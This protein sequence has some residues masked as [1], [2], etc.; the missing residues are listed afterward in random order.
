LVTREQPGG[1]TAGR[2]DTR[3][4][5]D[6][7]FHC[8]PGNCQL[9]VLCRKIAD[10]TGESMFRAAAHSFLAEVLPAQCFNR[11]KNRFGA[12]PG[13]SPFWGGYLPFCYPHWAAKFFW[14][15][16]REDVEGV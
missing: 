13:S 1:R 6:Y 10:A 3:W 14:M 9:S 7:S 8:V 5:G 11:N 15:R 4:Q 2:C 12:F 16:R